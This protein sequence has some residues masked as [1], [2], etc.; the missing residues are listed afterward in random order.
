MGLK[1]RSSCVLVF[2][3]LQHNTVQFHVRIYDP[4]MIQIALEV[5]IWIASKKSTR[6]K[7]KNAHNAS[8]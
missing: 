2:M 7:I 8:N 3:C 6:I 4:N 5:S 1:Q